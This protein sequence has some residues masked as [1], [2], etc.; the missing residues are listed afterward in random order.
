MILDFLSK[1]TELQKVPSSARLFV[2][3]DFVIR[4]NL[5][6]ASGRK[7]RMIDFILNLVPFIE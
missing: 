5:R 2:R 1:G 3:K 7:K 4:D 6:K